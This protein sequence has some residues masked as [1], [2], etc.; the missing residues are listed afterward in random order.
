MALSEE[1]YAEIR[2]ELDEC[3][4][5]FYFFDDDQDGLC[6]FLLLYRY[7][8]E[9]KGHI[10]KTTP[11]LDGK[12]AQKALE[13]G[14]DKVFVLDLAVLEDEFIDAITVPIIWIDHHGPYRKHR[15][16]YYNPKVRDEKDNFPTSYLCYRVVRQDLWLAVAGCVSDWFLPEFMSEFEEHYPGMIGAHYK[17][18]GDILYGDMN[19]GLLSR[20]LSFN[21]KGQSSDVMK[22][23]RTMIKVDDPREILEQSTPRGKFVWKRYQD[24]NKQFEPLMRQALKQAEQTKDS[25]ILFPYQDETSFTS[26]ISNVLTYKHPKKV[27]LICREKSGEMKCSLRSGHHN[28]PPIVEKC[29][30]GLQGHGGGH[31][32]ACGL[33]VAKHHFDEFIGRLKKEI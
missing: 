5:P 2:K 32:H 17:E 26:D 13:Y 23:I 7:K 31:E 1:Q 8:K 22:S 12:F 24:I 33:N 25:L 3:Q 16:R 29:L 30:V 14:A 28:L 15:V 19:L 9:G 18:P 10:V 11:R 6:S 27:I 20:V 4:K 21:L